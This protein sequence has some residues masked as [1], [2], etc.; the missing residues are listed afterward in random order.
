MSCLCEKTG[1]RTTG[2]IM[3]WFVILMVKQNVLGQ[4]FFVLFS[5]GL[6]SSKCDNSFRGW[7]GKYS[8]LQE[9]MTRNCF[10]QE[11]IEI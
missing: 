3:Q 6:S 7:T 11:E 2:P 8:F 5:L 9:K 10:V 4:L 1:F